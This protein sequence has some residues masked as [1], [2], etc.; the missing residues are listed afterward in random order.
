MS[1]SVFAV[2][3]AV[4]SWYLF[5]SA[6][7]VVGTAVGPRR[8]WMGRLHT[9]GGFAV[10][11]AWSW[12]GWVV[13]FHGAGGEA[14]WHLGSLEVPLLVDGL[15][16]TFLWLAGLLG[17]A[18]TWYSTVA[19]E[20]LQPAEFRRLTTAFPLFLAGVTGLFV[21]DDLSL[22]FTISWQLMALSSFVLIRGAGGEGARRAAIVYLAAVE[23]AY[24]AVTAAAVLLDSWKIGVDLHDVATAFGGRD[25]PLAG[26]ALGLLLLGFA[27]K[28]EAFPFGQRWLFLGAAAAP[29]PVGALLSGLVM[30]SGIFGLARILFWVVPEHPDRESLLWFSGAAL[31]AAGTVTLF[32]GTVQALR[33][34]DLGRLL[35]LSSVGQAGYLLFG[36]GAAVLLLATPDADGLAALALTAVL[37]H[38]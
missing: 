32:C 12:T 21:V 25:L 2:L 20:G 6:L 29:A 9:A 35:A 16:A 23:L 31:A 8:R 19:F 14:T 7:S 1:A 17:A 4:F 13:L 36:L 24:L 33:Q 5:S 22:G 30:K 27:V 3:L 38:A 18:V 15:S 11:G 10:L 26:V 34:S 28:A 37:Y